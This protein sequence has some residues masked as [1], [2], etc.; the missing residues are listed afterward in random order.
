M[1]AF[2]KMNVKFNSKGIGEIPATH[3]IVYR[4]KTR[5]GTIN[6]IGVAQKGRA[7]ARLREHLNNPRMTGFKV[8]IGQFHSIKDA[9][10]SEKNLIHRHKPKLNI[11]HNR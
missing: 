8:E 10:A 3:P 1:R 11:Q 4:L 5:M 9:K 7:R 2:K 6:Y